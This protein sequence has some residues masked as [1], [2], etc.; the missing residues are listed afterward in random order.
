[1]FTSLPMLNY[2]I[3]SETSFLCPSVTPHPQHPSRCSSFRAKKH[4][5]SL[6][7]FCPFHSVRFH[8]SCFFHVLQD[9]PAFL[10]LAVESTV[11]LSLFLS[12]F[13]SL[14]LSSLLSPVF[15][16]YCRPPASIMHLKRRR[17][18]D[19]RLGLASSEF[20]NIN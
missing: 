8:S 3:E 9:H 12:L 14:L 11:F 7:F 15:S 13:H 20:F 4:A 19:R 6:S 18:K 5:V 1:M 17:L 16:A 10:H 2:H